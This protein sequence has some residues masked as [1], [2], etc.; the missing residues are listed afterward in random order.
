MDINSS[1]KNNHSKPYPPKKNRIHLKPH[2]AAIRLTAVEPKK[3]SM[4]A[5]ANSTDNLIK[6]HCLIQHY[7]VLALVDTG[8]TSN[9]I[10]LD[11]LTQIDPDSQFV[12][13]SYYQSVKVGDNRFVKSIGRVT[14]PL[15]I[16]HN[17]FTTT[18]V[19]LENLSFELI[20]GMQF[21]MAYK[22][23]IDATE[24][25]VHFNTDTTF[26]VKLAVTTVV[27]A[28]SCTAVDAFTDTP[29]LTVKVISVIF[30]LSV[31][32]CNCTFFYDKKINLIISNNSTT[33][34]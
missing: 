30:F 13:E 25:S 21:L 29:E 19:I 3:N 7:D 31:I 14:L 20:L 33:K 18:F 12:I 23:V 1:G 9:Y 6:L 34:T 11:K 27:P 28:F 22:A 15:M 10:S 5:P 26:L 32:L 24:R 16:D 8:A 17:E 2:Q 4:A